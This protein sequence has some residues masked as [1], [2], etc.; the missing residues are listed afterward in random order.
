VDSVDNEIHIV[1]LLV[2]HHGAT[3]DATETLGYEIV[4][5]ANKISSVAAGVHGGGDDLM[6]VG[7]VHQIT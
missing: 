3:V 6:N 5:V 1:H 4:P 2:D 7:E